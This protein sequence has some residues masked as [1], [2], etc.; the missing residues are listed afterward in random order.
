MSVNERFIEVQENEA[1][2]AFRESIVTLRAEAASIAGTSNIGKVIRTLR[3]IDLLYQQATPHWAMLTAVRT[4]QEHAAVGAI[5]TALDD[6]LIAFADAMASL[7]VPQVINIG[8]GYNSGGAR[9]QKLAALNRAFPYVEF[10]V[11]AGIAS[12]ATALVAA[13][14]ALLVL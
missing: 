8:A 2:V 5:V 1:I 14:D 11:P 12:K 9:A 3:T 13:I 4:P 6:L 7:G 10:A